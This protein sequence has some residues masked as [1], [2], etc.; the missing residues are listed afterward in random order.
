LGGVRLISSARITFAKTGPCTNRS[1]RCPVVRSSSITSVPVMSEGIRSGVN[2]IRLKSRLIVRAIVEISS[3]LASPGTPTTSACP[4]AE[5]AQRR[6]GGGRRARICSTTS[7][8]PTMTFASISVVA[9][10]LN[11]QHVRL[12]KLLG[13]FDWHFH[14]DE[15]E[16]FLI[17]KGTL[18]LASVHRVGPSGDAPPGARFVYR[19]VSPGLRSVAVVA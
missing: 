6:L 14:A 15:D 9:A 5:D 2:W 19:A 4:T 16:M 3:V 1:A 17:H 18:R 10:S 13:A 12:A 11:G 8:C 7:S